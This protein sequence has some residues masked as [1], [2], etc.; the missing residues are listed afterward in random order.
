MDF[1]CWP[2]YMIHFIITLTV[3]VTHSLVQIPAFVGN[4]YFCE[5]G[6]PTS[7]YEKENCTYLTLSGMVRGVVLRRVTVV[8]LLVSHMMKFLMIKTAITPLLF[9][10]NVYLTM[11]SQNLEFIHY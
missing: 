2:T 11:V 8:L 9:A 10:T 7:S 1:S 5:S 3:H 4:D 6:N